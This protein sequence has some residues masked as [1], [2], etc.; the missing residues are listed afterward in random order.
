MRGLGRRR[1]SDGPRGG[2]PRSG[3]AAAPV[4]STRPS[5]PMRH[6]STKIFVRFASY[7]HFF[8]EGSSTKC[9]VQGRSMS[10][11]QSNVLLR[12]TLRYA[13][14]CSAIHVGLR[15]I[16]RELKHIDPR[17]RGDCINRV[18][19]SLHAA[20]V[21]VTCAFALVAE[22]PFS[23]ML[24]LRLGGENVNFFAGHSR[25]LD[26]VLPITLG[27]FC[28]DSVV[29]MIDREVYMP[30]MMV[31][32]IGSLTTWPVA[33][34]TDTHH[35]YLLYLLSTELSSPF[36][37]QMVFFLPKAKREGTLFHTFC[38]VMLLLIF[39]FVR[40]CPVPLVILS[41]VDAS[42]HFLNLPGYIQ[43]ITKITFPIPAA[44]NILWF[45]QIISVAM[46]ECPSPKLN[47]AA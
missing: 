40:V 35:V 25:T 33:Y 11:P 6:F 10:E 7:I 36:L 44:M 8:R 39:F 9:D 4:G 14:V 31:H 5:D 32:H 38:G 26:W 19:A 46:K 34:M 28:Y 21:G 16:V 45:Y 23:G 27:Y 20:I 18:I 30:L 2:G 22:E 17:E 43:L 3:T 37:H 24:P 13:C 1:I 47:K 29:M 41:L 42:E 12:L 15:P